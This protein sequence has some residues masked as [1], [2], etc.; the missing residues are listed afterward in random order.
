MKKKKI[1][2]IKKNKKN[3]IYLLLIRGIEK[4]IILIIIYIK[5]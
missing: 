4:N 2:I 1:K 5:N 3:E